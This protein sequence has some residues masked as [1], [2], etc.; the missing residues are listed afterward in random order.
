LQSFNSQTI[1][2]GKGFAMRTKVRF[3]M[4]VAAATATATVICS[5]VFCF[6][7]SVG[8]QSRMTAVSGVNFSVSAPLPDNLK[9]FTGKNVYIHLRSGK[10]LQGYVK[11]VGDHWV[12]LEKIAGREFFD[13]LIRLDDISAVEVK[14][15]E[16][17]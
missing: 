8:A 1:K 7:P 12:H 17:K 2:N 14:F 10:A 3:A 6:P 4:F 5:A 13:A 15:R 16:Y 9:S 11:S